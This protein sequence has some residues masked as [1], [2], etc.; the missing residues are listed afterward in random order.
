MM[1]FSEVLGWITSI[2]QAWGLM[3]FIQAAIFILV[4]VGVFAGI[5]NA[6]QK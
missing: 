2:L 3:G 1:G 6:L 5:R 4:A